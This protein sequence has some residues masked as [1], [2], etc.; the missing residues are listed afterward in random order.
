MLRFEF[1][2]SHHQRFFERIIAQYFKGEQKQDVFQEFSLHLFG[3]Y[4][5]KFPND[6]HLFDSKAWLRTILVNFCISQIRKEQAQK[7]SVWTKTSSLVIL[8][9][10][11]LVKLSE[12]DVQNLYTA[13][14]GCVSK[15]EALILKMKFEYKCT[16]KEIERRLGVQHAD[17]LIA[18]IKEKVRK[19]MGRIDLEF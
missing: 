1:V 16:A 5:Q 10:D 2:L 3:L 6:A 4:Q 7:N 19:K 13:A 11:E 14:L 17:V 12:D 18:R 8:I 9:S 15:K